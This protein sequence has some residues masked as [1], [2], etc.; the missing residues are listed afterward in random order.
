M[1][2]FATVQ[3]L[4]APTLVPSREI[5]ENF[6]QFFNENVL[7]IKG[8]INPAIYN[9]PLTLDELDHRK[10]MA[11]AA[12]KYIRNAR[13][14]YAY[15]LPS[16]ASS[17]SLNSFVSLIHLILFSLPFCHEIFVSNQPLSSFDS[18]VNVTAALILLFCLL[19]FSTREV[20]IAF[21]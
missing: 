11:Q 17:R 19:S 13:I 10:L 14:S 5:C 9:T 1:L 8:S 16:R 3:R 21:Y 18:S 12:F 2:F 6:A 4:T 7:T 20:Q 15:F